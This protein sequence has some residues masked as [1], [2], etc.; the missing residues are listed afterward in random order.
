[1][2][3]PYL[4]LR[5][6]LDGV[7][8]VVDRVNGEAT[9]DAHAEAVKQA[10]VADRIVLTK[11]DLA[12]RR[13]TRGIVRAAARAQSGRAD[14]RCR[15]R[16]SDRRADCSAAGC[17]IRTAKSPT[18]R[19]GSP[20]RPMPTRMRTITRSSSRPRRLDRN[21]HDE[22]I[23]SFV[24]TSRRRDPGRHARDVPRTVARELRRPA[25]APQGHREARRNA[26]H[27][28]G[29][30]RRAARLPPDR[31]ARALAGRRSPHP[32]G[33]HH[34]RPARA[35][36][37]R[38][39]RGL[40]RRARARPARPGGADPTIRWSPSAAW[41]AEPAALAPHR[42]THDPASP[43]AAHQAAWGESHGPDLAAAISAGRARRDRSVAL[44][45]AGRAVRGKL[46]ALRRAR[47]LHLHGQDHH[48]RR[49][50]RRFAR[51]CRLAAGARPAARRARRRHDAERA[52][53]SG[54]DRRHPARRHDGGERQPALQAARTGIPAQRFRRRG[55]RRAGEFRLRAARGA[56]AHQGEAR[57]GRQ[58]GRH[59][60]R[61]ERH[62]RQFRRAPRQED[63]AGLRLAQLDFLQRRA[64]RGRQA[65]VQP[66]EDRARRHRLPAI[67][68][69]HHRRR[70]GRHAAAPES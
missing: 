64:R 54:G 50:G 52:A 57:P 31:A 59:A 69:R 10:A 51:A 18:S 3:H 12:E 61:P 34:P 20:P 58:H 41:T 15:Q 36:R 30:A 38:A 46:P 55:D 6:R 4:V 65:A 29:G 8:T 23:G 7:V 47:R 1:M 53:I 43:A 17:T 2:A 11:T 67:Y 19:N 66:A 33:V 13:A 48:L 26:G 62:D 35:H 56:A 25:A 5:Y 9:L 37:A 63:G 39:V 68:R 49:T 21:R 70:Q 40:P 60:G 27:A 16:R 42:K 28:G 32:A 22:H 44:C 45:F 14:P 24:L